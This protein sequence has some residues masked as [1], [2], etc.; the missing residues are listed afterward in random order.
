[1]SREELTRFVLTI[2]YDGGAFHGWQIQ[3]DVR[4]VQGDLEAVIER[5]SGARRPVVGSGRTDTGVHAT[6]Q[7]AAVDLP[8]RWSARRLHRA[9]N[10]LLEDDVWIESVRPAPSRFHA[11]YD[12][13]RRTYRYRIGT[14]RLAASPFHRRWCWPLGEELDLGRMRQASDRL[15]GDHSFRAFAKT[16]Q[17]ERGDRCTV[18][19]AAWDPWE[20]LGVSFTIRAN[21][22]LHHMVRYLV[23]TL[24]EVGLHRRPASHLETLLDDPDT[25]LVT[26]PPAPPEGL[27]LALVEYPEEAFLTTTTET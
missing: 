17:P 19:E 7:V 8:S 21:R 25:P 20:D 4:T 2:H 6:G 23:G 1:L 10:G 26:S 22:Y 24:V 9:L 3:P 11:R 12:A 15:V 27:V 18:E 16:G 14:S 13:T 5:I